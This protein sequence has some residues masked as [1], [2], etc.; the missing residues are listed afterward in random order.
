MTTV[1]TRQSVWTWM[2]CDVKD[3]HDVLAILGSVCLCE[4]VRDLH[5][6]GIST[7]LRE[8]SGLVNPTLIEMSADSCTQC[9]SIC[10][11][12]LCASTHQTHVRACSCVL[13]VGASVGVHSLVAHDLVFVVDVAVLVVVVVVVVVVV[14]VVVVMVLVVVDILLLLLSLLISGGGSGSS[15]C[16]SCSSSSSSSSSSSGSSSSSY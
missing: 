13:V 5:A 6:L 8:A 14:I 11:V 15:S 1:M 4:W 16:R 12:H 3:I 2:T 10:L 7:N 9:L